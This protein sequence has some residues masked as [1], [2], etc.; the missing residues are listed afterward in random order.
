MGNSKYQW[1]TLHRKFRRKEKMT[2]KELREIVRLISTCPVKLRQIKL[3]TDP[4]EFATQCQYYNSINTE[5][6]WNNLVKEHP[7][8]AIP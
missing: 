1:S 8:L 2:E 7:W 5:E 4:H 3:W 6:S